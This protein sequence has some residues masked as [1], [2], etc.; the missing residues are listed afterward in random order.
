MKNDIFTRPWFENEL[1]C[2]TCFR[3]LPSD[4]FFTKNGCIWCNPK[5]HSKKEN[6]ERKY[7]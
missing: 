3:I 4:K 2:K 5:Y 7:K 1:E 6:N